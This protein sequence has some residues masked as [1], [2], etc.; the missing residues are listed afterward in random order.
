[1]HAQI[2]FWFHIVR[3]IDHE[4][5]KFRIFDTTVRTFTTKDHSGT[6]DKRRRGPAHGA[7]S[8]I[9]P[10]RTC[11]IFV[12]AEPLSIFQGNFISPRALTPF[13]QHDRLSPGTSKTSVIFW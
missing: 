12:P 6:K 8:P 1:P 4:K 13:I 10:Y 9:H 11:C 2:M 3:G 7:V 5:W